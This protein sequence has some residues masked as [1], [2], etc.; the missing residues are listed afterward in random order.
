MPKPRIHL[1]APDNWGFS[2]GD[3]HSGFMLCGY[4]TKAEAQAAA[5]QYA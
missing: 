3:E 2:I 4:A 5:A 1:Y